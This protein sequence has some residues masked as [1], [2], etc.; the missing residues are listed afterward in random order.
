MTASGVQ[1]Q[2]IK[3][4]IEN[5]FVISSWIEL[6]AIKEM[7]I[8]MP[9]PLGVGVEWELRVFGLSRSLSFKSGKS[10]FNKKKLVAKPANAKKR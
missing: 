4:T 7:T 2:V 9:P 8:A 1:I 10:A 3:E 6:M 5:S